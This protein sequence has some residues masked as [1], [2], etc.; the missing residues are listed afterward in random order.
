MKMSSGWGRVLTKTGQSLVTL[1]TVVV[2]VFLLVRL[3]PGDPVK[4]ILG[5]E[6]TPE[7]EAALR[8]QLQLDKS[9]PE[10]FGNYV[11][12][13][14]RGDMGASVAQ[15]GTEVS[16]IIFN[17]LPTTLSV[18]AVGMSL[19]VLAGIAAGMT[20]ARSKRPGIDLGVRTWAMVL[21]ATPT[22][23]IG[24]LLILVF[25]VQLRWFP[26]GG[27]DEQFP[28]ALGYLVLPG[29]ALSTNMA[30]TIAR[31]VRQ[32]AV[33]VSGQQYM[34]AA[35]SRGIADRAL[36]VKHVLPNSLLPVI[37]LMGISFG[38]L[39]T[40]AII[41][42][43]V[44][45]LPGLGAEM[46]KAVAQRDYPVIQGIALISALAVI[47]GNYLAEIAYTLVDPRARKS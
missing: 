22:F 1:G 34:E 40:G 36:A 27:W 23:L 30:P 42:E 45:G 28:A 5:V 41:V 13:L 35:L 44:F 15:R 4:V 25:S 8:Q 14:L 32:A 26:A 7:S 12:G 29:I 11:A 33:D 47:V 16:D 46:T 18:V 39:L 21:F 3:I 17:A 9:I 37:T 2:L 24:L 6:A 20:A 19:A 31:A 10:Q 43:A 38:T